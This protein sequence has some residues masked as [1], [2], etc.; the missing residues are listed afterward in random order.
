[1]LVSKVNDKAANRDRAVKT[2]ESLLMT[3]RL[4]FLPTTVA[5][6]TQHIISSVEM[7]QF[8]ETV[9][10][11]IFTMNLLKFFELSIHVW[12]ENCTVFSS[13]LTVQLELC[14]KLSV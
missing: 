12:R 14:K 4:F 7:T 6:V 11:P 9:K 10:W 13:V 1:V 2:I 3:P 8:S 5:L